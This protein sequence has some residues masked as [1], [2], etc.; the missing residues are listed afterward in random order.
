MHDIHRTSSICM[1]LYVIASYGFH[2]L[3]SVLLHLGSTAV[4]LLQPSL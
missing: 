3:D 2:K 4:G 1:H